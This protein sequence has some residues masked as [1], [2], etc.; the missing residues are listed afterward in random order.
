MKLTDDGAKR[1]IV[2]QANAAAVARREAQQLQNDEF[3]SWYE[4]ELYALS[5]LCSVFRLNQQQIFAY[6]ERHGFGTLLEM[7]VERFVELFTYVPWE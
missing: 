5:K 2:I 6:L 7:D 1:E 4:K 3:F